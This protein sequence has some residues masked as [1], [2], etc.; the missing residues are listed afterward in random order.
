[1]RAVA[2]EHGAPDEAD[3][4]FGEVVGPWPRVP[5][6]VL[7]GR[8]DRLL[9]LEFVERLAGERL[10]VVVDVID[11]GHLPALARPAALAD[12]LTSYRAD[13][14]RKWEDIGGLLP[15]ET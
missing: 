2:V 10:G 7:A 1:M 14:H 8:Y 6:R 15:S 12:R 9:P 3:R 13:A 5:T 11:T 4:A